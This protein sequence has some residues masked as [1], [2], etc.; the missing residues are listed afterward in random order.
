MKNI[1]DNL[2]NNNAIS[3]LNLS[4]NNFNKVAT[5]NLII[6]Y[7]KSNIKIKNLNLAGCHIGSG[8]KKFLSILKDN[9]IICCLDIS[10][11]DFGGNKEII[12]IL[13]T[14]LSENYY[15][16]YLYLDGNFIN[17]QDFEKIINDGIKE[18][19]NLLLLSLKYNKI[20]LNKI[21]S[22][23]PNRNMIENIKLNNYIKDITF[24]GNPIKSEKNV[25]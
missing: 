10:S 20:T 16:K 8:M 11:N 4:Y 17:D 14:Y 19:K 21:E 24:D 3:S 22:K 2:E 13:C 5:S 7:I 9:K 18:N 15:I 12:E 23:V 25:N 1:L 6:K